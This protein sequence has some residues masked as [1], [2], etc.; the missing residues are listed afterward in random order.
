MLLQYAQP[1]ILSSGMTESKAQK[2]LAEEE[3]ARLAAGGVALHGTSPA[4][5]LVFAMELE[6]SQ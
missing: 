1:L 6:D 5:F 3:D 4:A 2:D